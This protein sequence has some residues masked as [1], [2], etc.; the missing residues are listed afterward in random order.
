MPS[1]KFH[2]TNQTFSDANNAYTNEYEDV[3]VLGRGASG[4][5]Q[6]ARRRVDQFEVNINN[7]RQL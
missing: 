4:F 6:L 5:V 3:S 2:K 7:F 1:F